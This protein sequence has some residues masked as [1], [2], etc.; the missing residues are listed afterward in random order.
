MAAQDE[1]ILAVVTEVR[2]AITD[3]EFRRVLRKL[4]GSL[5]GR[6]AKLTLFGADVCS[7]FCTA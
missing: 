6:L 4:P 7:T 3:A 5:D 2:P 1:I